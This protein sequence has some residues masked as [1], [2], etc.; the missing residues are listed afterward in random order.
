M[1]AESDGLCAHLAP[2]ESVVDVGDATLVENAR[3]MDGTVGVTDRRVLFVADNEGFT[4]VGHDHISAVESR[5]RQTLT[6]RAVTYW[7]LAAVGVF[8][9]SSVSVILVV[10]AA[11]SLGLFLVLSTVGSLV[12][13]AYVWGYGVDLEWLPSEVETLFVDAESQALLAV[14]FGL[15]ATVS[16][17]GVVALTESLFAL[18]FTLVALCGIALV[19]D[20][21]R[22]LRELNRTGESHRDERDVHI[23]LLN[24]HTVRIRIASEAR[25]DRELS[26]LA[27]ADVYTPRI[28]ADRV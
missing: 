13:A 19:D 26:R 25:I 2:G 7:L 20:A 10:M 28:E 4:D 22:R 14:G 5:P 17:I 27:C 24:G 11:T 16:F 8:L 3:Q 21:Y 23:H 15:L 18:P 12:A 6:S 1:T 9:V